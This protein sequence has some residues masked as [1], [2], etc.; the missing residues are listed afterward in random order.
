MAEPDTED[1]LR[2]E[3]EMLFEKIRI[4]FEHT[5]RLNALKGIMESA[6]AQ[7]TTTPNSA[8][9]KP[10]VATPPTPPTE[11]KPQAVR[12]RVG[13]VQHVVRVTLERS[14]APLAPIKIVETAK[15]KD[16]QTEIKIG[17]VRMALLAMEKR[18]QVIRNDIGEWTVSPRH[19]GRMA[20]S[21]DIMTGQDAPFIPQPLN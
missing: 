2:F 19:N 20:P 4:Y 12:A 11:N 1:S 3:W 17:S 13:S 10:G 5:G 21:P 18:G 7:L 16:P 15:A 8:S 14:I 9:V 6:Q